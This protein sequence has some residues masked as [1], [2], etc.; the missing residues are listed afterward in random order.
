MGTLREDIVRTKEGGR[1]V[2]STFFSGKSRSIVAY[3][4]IMVYMLTPVE[5]RIIRHG[6]NDRG[7]E[8][9]NRGGNP[10]Q[11]AN[12]RRNI[13]RKLNHNY[14]IVDEKIE[15]EQNPSLWTEVK[16]AVIKMVNRIR[17]MRRV[18]ASKFKEED[19]KPL[20]PHIL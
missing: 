7:A 10:N 18:L 14:N 16:K 6:A 12:P 4:M 3:L 1:A 15:L 8:W 2:N 20:R 19:D 9:V 11:G 5:G 13:E 17:E